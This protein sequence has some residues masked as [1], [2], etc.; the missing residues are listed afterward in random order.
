MRI[1]FAA[2][3][4]NHAEQ[5]FNLQLATKLEEQGFSVFLPQRDGVDLKVEPYRDMS[6]KDIS[7]EIFD[8]D[9]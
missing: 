3:F 7:A 4:F 9:R 1:Y 5:A 2:P 8:L 6:G